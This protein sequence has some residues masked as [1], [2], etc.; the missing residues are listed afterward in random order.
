MCNYVYEYFY[1]YIYIYI[2]IILYILLYIYDDDIWFVGTN[3][4]SCRPFALA[5]RN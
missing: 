5:G 1:K 3:I 4:K 2:Y